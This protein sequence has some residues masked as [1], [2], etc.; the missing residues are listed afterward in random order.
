[1][2]KTHEMAKKRYI[3]NPRC[4]KE[5]IWL[6]GAVVKMYTAASGS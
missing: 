2:Q 6:G 4:G 1:M 5:F 3:K